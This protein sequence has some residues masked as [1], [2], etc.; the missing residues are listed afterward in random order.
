MIKPTI[1]AI[2][3]ASCIPVRLVAA[4]TD[5]PGQLEIVSRAAK[6]PDSGVIQLTEHGYR[7]WGPELVRYRI[8]E[9]K[10]PSGKRVLSTV[11]VEADG[12]A[13]FRVPA[14][15]PISLQPLDAEGQAVA[16]LRRWMSAQAGENVSCGGC[17][18]CESGA[19]P[20]TAQRIALTQPVR[21]ITPWRSPVHE[22]QPVLDKFCVGCHDGRKD[23]PPDLRRDQGGYVVYRGSQLD[24]QFLRNDKKD[25]LGRYGAVFE[26]SYVALRQFVRVGGLERDLHLLPPREFAADTSELIQMLAQG[27][28]NVKLGWEAWDRLV[29]WIDLNAPCHGTWAETTKIPSDQYQRRLEWRALYGGVVENG[30]AIPNTEADHESPKP[31]MPEPEPPLPA[32]AL[33]VEGWPSSAGKAKALQE[34]TGPATRS[35]YGTTGKKVIRGGSR[36]DRPK[37]IRSASR[38]AYDRW[39]KVFNVGFRVTIDPD[40]KRLAATPAHP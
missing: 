15:T 35:G 33:A 3:I 10:F 29:T 27:H 34:A 36:R 6:V 13:L 5:A 23:A 30:E 25:L 31:V 37:L 21:D 26:P 7:R 11:P 20:D 19:L 39:Q 1:L 38:W 2:V 28:H 24:G 12:S 8:D 4:E 22:V 14:K 17:H 40:A 18:D 16:L 9:K 32:A